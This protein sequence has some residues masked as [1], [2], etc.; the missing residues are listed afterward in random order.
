MNMVVKPKPKLKSKREWTTRK[1]NYNRIMRFKV[2][3][4]GN[5]EQKYSK[6][7]FKMFIY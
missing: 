6:S 5:N 2:A 4:F 7:N 3:D 1:R